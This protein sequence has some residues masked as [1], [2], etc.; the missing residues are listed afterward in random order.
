MSASKWKPYPEY[1]ATEFS[2]IGKIPKHW[3]ICRVKNL[4]ELSKEKVIEENPQILS[5]TQNGIKKRDISNFEGQIAATYDGYH[6]VNI[7]DIVF[8]PMDLRSGFVD[9]SPFFGIISPAYTILKPKIDVSKKYYGMWFQR[10]YLQYI[11]WP[12]GKGVSYEHRWTLSDETLLNFPILKP[13][14]NEQIRISETL[15]KIIQQTSHLVNQLLE[16]DKLLEEK[17]FKIISMTVTKGINSENELKDSRIPWIGMIPNHWKTSKAKN[18]SWIFAP[19]RNKP[20]QN[21]HAN[22]LPWITTSNIG[23]E[24]VSSE[25]TELWVA[26]EEIVINGSRI[27]PKNSVIATCVGEFGVSS[28]NFEDC[29]INQQL[30]AYVPESIHPEY[31]RYVIIASKQYFESVCNVTTLSYVNKEKFGEMPIPY[32]NISEQKEIASWLSERLGKIHE[33][34]SKIKK[35]IKILN[36]YRIAAISDIVTGK[37][38]VQ[39]L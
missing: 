35:S 11:F 39:S 12:F 9:S 29:I 25:D 4:F 13:P 37:K 31:L 16:K 19:E 36:E 2:W 26:E 34:K 20:K 1:K 24:Y 21:S 6:R 30:Q 18:H 28:I 8:N 32:P 14:L 27:L 38:D 23:N 5:L 10:H 3:S 7:G 17:S 22:G 33:A 15:E